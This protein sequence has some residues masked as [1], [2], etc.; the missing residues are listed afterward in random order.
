MMRR[1]PFNP[2]KPLKPGKPLQR[3]TAM[4]RGT[5]FKTPAASA[6][7]L[8]VA[9]VQVKARAD[10]KARE[11]KLPKPIKSRGMKGRPPTAEE[12]RFMDKMG[13]LPCIACLKDGWTNHVISLHHIDGRTKPGAHFLVLPLCGGHHQDGTGANATLIA[14]H[15]Y[16]ARFEERYGTQRELLAECVDMLGSDVRSD[17]NKYLEAA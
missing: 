10:K 17:Y 7:L 3:K 13:A 9:A 11:R 4:S 1:S 14:V 16:K 6:G 2:G 12:A 15:P 8:R 5:G